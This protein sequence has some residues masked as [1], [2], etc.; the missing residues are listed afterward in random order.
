MKHPDYQASLHNPKELSRIGRWIN[1][2]LLEE[3]I[4]TI[5][6]IGI[7]GAVIGGVVSARYNKNLIIVRKDGEKNHYESPLQG[8]GH[9]TLPCRYAF[10]DDLIATGNTLARVQSQLGVAELILLYHGQYPSYW[11]E[12]KVRCYCKS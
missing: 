10:V 1:K 5:A 8:P 11:K 4:D 6:V 7:S 3:G 2:C 12:R 9:L